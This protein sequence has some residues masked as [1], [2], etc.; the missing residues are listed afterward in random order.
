MESGEYSTNLDTALHYKTVGNE[1]YKNGEF[2]A[3]MGQYHRALLYIKSVYAGQKVPYSAMMGPSR[4]PATP[5][6]RSQQ[7]NIDQLYADCQANLAACL[8]SVEPASYGRVL[9]C[10]NEALSKAPS[11]I[12]A[13]YRRGVAL[14]HLHRYEEAIETF[15]TA[16]R[17]QNKLDTNMSRYLS[18]CRQ[19]LQQQDKQLRTQ[20]QAMF[21]PH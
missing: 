3:A 9:E 11:H 15:S 19:E 13:H 2:T 14:Y 1:R 7:Q 8:L 12:K 17:L 18:L 6:T 20:C 16:A 5:L 4:P 10:C 21:A